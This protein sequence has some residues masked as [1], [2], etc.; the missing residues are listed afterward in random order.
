[1]DNISFKE[2]HISQIPAIEL[3]Q[4]LGYNYIMPDEALEMRGRKTSNVLLEDILRN[5]RHYPIN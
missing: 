4:K 2:N 1:M 5:Q 3:L